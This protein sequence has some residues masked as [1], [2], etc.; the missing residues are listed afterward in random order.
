MGMRTTFKALL[1]TSV[2]IAVSVA[3]F[4][5]PEVSTETLY[6]G[7]LSSSCYLIL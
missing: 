6:R 4:V 5:S 3:R 2:E 7:R 1:R